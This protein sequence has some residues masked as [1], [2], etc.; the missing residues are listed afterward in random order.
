MLIDFDVSQN[1]SPH[2]R[3][4]SKYRGALSHGNASKSCRAV[5]SDVG[6]EVGPLSFFKDNAATIYVIANTGVMLDLG[7]ERSKEETALTAE[8]HCRLDFSYPSTPHATEL[9]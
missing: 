4:R 3:S 5:H 8:P 9:L 7:Q 2:A 1:F 6:L